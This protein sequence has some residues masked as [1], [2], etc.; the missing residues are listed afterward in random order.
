MREHLGPNGANVIADATISAQADAAQ[1]L[2]PLAPLKAYRQWVVVLLVPLVNGK[3][4]KLPIDY[5]TGNVTAKDSGGALNPA[6]WTD[7]ATAAA[8]ATQWGASFS[9]GFVLTANDPFFCLDIDACHD[10]TAWSP[11]ALELLA[12]L[13][14]TAVEVSQSGRGLHVWG[15]GVVP[16]HA[17]KRVDLGIEL[18]TEL[19]FIVLGRP[20]ATGDMSRPCPTIEAFAAHYFPPRA[21]AGSVDIPDDGPCPEWRGPTD[22]ADLLRR[23]MRSHSAAGVFGQRATFADLWTADAAA[24]GRAYPPDASSAEP[25]DR[26]SADAA[27]AQH[28]AFW[29]GRHV[30]RIE[31]LMRQ[32]ALAREKW[33][34]RED[35]LV[36]RTIRGA[37]AR[38]ADV[39]KDKAPA[40]Q[41]APNE[42]PVGMLVPEDPL[43]TARAVIRQRF[44]HGGMP[45]LKYWQ[46]S[47]YSWTGAAWAELPDAD[48][49]A[50]VY[51]FIDRHGFADFRPTARR[52]SDVVD[53]LKAAANLEARHAPPCWIGEASAL[54]ASELVS[55]ANGL[56][57]LATRTL[58]PASP[59]FFNLN[60]T[61]FRFDAD[62]PQP[63]RWLQFLRTV[64]PNDPE[65]IAALQEIFGYLLTPD[66]RQ[67][68]LFLVVGPKRS[69]KGT[70]ARVLTEMLGPSKATLNK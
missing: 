16:P 47:F 57:H 4:D 69:G 12:A 6:M 68:K 64:W 31:R 3:T 48:A 34:D 52:V 61:P 30:A 51:D 1:A 29:T 56:L 38:Q 49:R 41:Q 36:E 40:A 33:D 46:G 37:C 22:D 60:A 13:P 2:G 20:G 8:L 63:A 45:G 27:L 18:Y 50:A 23:A 28:L 19:R 26:S 17:K 7:Y 5:R 32:S 9:V 67:Q 24:L 21:G 58:H 55:C 15:Q 39:L 62:A 10:G 44:M 70:I 65:A 66:T 35:Y 25:Y 43:T 53:A 54:P 42:A 59:S 11:Q 14:G